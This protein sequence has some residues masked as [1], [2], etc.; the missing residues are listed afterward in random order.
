[1]IY[2]RIFLYIM[3]LVLVIKYKPKIKTP[4]CEFCRYHCPNSNTCLQYY[5]QPDNSIP[6]KILYDKFNLYCPKFKPLSFNDKSVIYYNKN[7]SLNKILFSIYKIIKIIFIGILI[8]KL[9]DILKFLIIQN[10]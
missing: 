2:L 7:Y 8:Y 5:I 1:M 10:L 3:L 6:S 4:N 9:S